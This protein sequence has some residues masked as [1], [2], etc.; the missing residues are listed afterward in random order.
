MFRTSD[1]TGTEVQDHSNLGI[2]RGEAWGLRI[3]TYASY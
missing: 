1:G 2:F 3:H